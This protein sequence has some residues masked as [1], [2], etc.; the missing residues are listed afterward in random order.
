VEQLESLDPLLAEVDRRHAQYLRTSLRQVRYQMSN[1]DGNFKERLVSLAQGLARLQER[2]VADLPEDTPG[3]RQT[4]VQAPDRGSFYTMP[5]GRAPFA[6]ASITRPLL[7]PGDAEA[8]R[9]VAL[10]EIGAG[11][12][13]QRIQQFVS[14][15]FNGHLRLRADEL[16]P[17]FYADMQWALCT[18]AYAHHSEV[19]YGV[20]AAEG[21]PVE[22]GS[23]R[24]QPF[25]LVKRENG[26]HVYS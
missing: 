26:R 25:E 20:E 11:I 18:L 7:D 16:P 10:R 17:D 13:P 8:L 14:R 23:Y 19:G 2:G 1:A 6:P 21:D 12:T 3:P 9:R 22:I 4:P 15:F 5:I 24:V